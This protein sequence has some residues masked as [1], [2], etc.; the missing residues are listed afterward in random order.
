M[1][2]AQTKQG[3]LLIPP[4]EQPVIFEPNV[5]FGVGN[6]GRLLGKGFGGFFPLSIGGFT[7]FFPDIR[8]TPRFA[9]GNCL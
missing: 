7:T 1:A 6:L 9:V 3:A 2:I 4:V 8:L 5:D